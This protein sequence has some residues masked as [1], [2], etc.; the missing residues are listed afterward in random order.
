MFLQDTHHRKDLG[1]RL[2]VTRHDGTTKG[3]D[4]FRQRAWRPGALGGCAV[5]TQPSQTEPG[6][7]ASVL[8]TTC[9]YV[10]RAK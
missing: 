6:S 7:V 8:G 4:Q 10:F 5:G 2:R 9:L 3:F 1:R